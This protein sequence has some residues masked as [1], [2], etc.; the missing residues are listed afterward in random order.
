MSVPET[1]F[2]GRQFIQK[3]V[4]KHTSLLSPPGA[5][6]PEW[7]S[8]ILEI[9]ELTSFDVK[10]KFEIFGK[11]ID[12]RKPIN[13][14]Q[15]SFTQNA[16]PKSFSKDI[17]IR[18]TT[19][20]SAKVVWEVNR[21]QFLTLIAIKYNQTG[22][23]DYKNLFRSICESWINDNPFLEGVN[24]HSNIEVNLRLITWFLC[25]EIMDINAILRDDPD[26][27]EFVEKRFVPCIYK[28]CYFSCHNP[29]KFS[30]ANNHLIAENAGLFIASSFWKFKESA[31]WRR[32]AKAGLEKEIIRQHS[33]DGINKEEAAEYIQFITDFF[34]LAYIVGMKNGDDFSGSYSGQLKK[35]I[36]YISDFL[37]CHGNFPGYGDEDDGKVC[38]LSSTQQDNNFKSIITSGI[39]LFQDSRL[40]SD[41]AFFDLKNMVLLGDAGKREFDMV[42][43]EVSLKPSVF[44]PEEGH[45]ILRKQTDK[46]KEIYLHFSASPLGYLSIAAHGHADCLSFMLN[47]DGQPVFVDPGTYTY[48]TEP[49]F[50]KYFIGTV[51]HNT[52]RID[53]LDQA[54][55]RGPTLWTN[56]Y[57]PR[58][59]RAESD[60]NLDMVEASHTGYLKTGV[61][62][63]RKILFDKKRDI[64]EIQD[65]VN[66]LDNRSHL[67]ELPF[68]L[69]PDSVLKPGAN[70]N[71][72]IH[73]AGAR[74]L[75][76]EADKRLN[77]EVKHGETNPVIG[78]HSH[79]FLHKQPT[80][81][82]IFTIESK[83]SIEIITRIKILNH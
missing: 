11:E 31:R 4:E 39:V 17:N 71:Y 25:W 48:H 74:T 45:F 79:S 32:K 23:E 12:F 77:A 54:L 43:G 80:N 81:V 9:G 70:T 34:L 66:V 2:R 59:I 14:H 60:E 26:F 41:D 55:N 15:D 19:N 53:N 29:S 5:E 56:H 18:N 33:P 61:N 27:K 10:E 1:L 83:S 44:Y 58:L 3:Q 75:L 6:L 82:L 13:W 78:W 76:L 24:W 36:S 28:H 69:H 73:T 47:V 38:I 51:A 62:H 46:D 52:I 7:P 63:I 22:E 37:D 50:R 67:I 8:S 65:R 20:I 64:I 16:F 49:E 57:K 68:H 40:K 35:I 42:P 72:S 30:S 21:L